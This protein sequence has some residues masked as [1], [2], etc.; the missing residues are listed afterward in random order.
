MGEIRDRV[1]ALGFRKGKMHVL[2]SGYKFPW[3][4]CFCL[5]PCALLPI[6]GV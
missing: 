1:Q 6:L 3:H 5:W 2:F 4:P